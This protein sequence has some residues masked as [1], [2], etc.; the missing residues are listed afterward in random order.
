M[1]TVQLRVEHRH[2][3]RFLKQRHLRPGNKYFTIGSS[4][5]A[6]FRL[7]G[8]DVSGIHAI[9]EFREDSWWVSD[10]GT[11][12]GN[13]AGDK[14]AGDL[15]EHKISGPMKFEI[16]AHTLDVK[17]CEVRRVLFQKEARDIESSN[18]ENLV[19]QVVIRQKSHVVETQFLPIEQNFEFCY[20]IKSEVLPPPKTK[21]WV[22][23]T[24]GNLTV[25]QRLVSLS[26][27]KTQ[28][29][30]WNDILPHDM[31]KSLAQ[32]A[33]VML[34]LLFVFTVPYIG[35]KPEET[36]IPKVLN[37]YTQMVYD[38]KVVKRKVDKSEKITASLMNRGKPKGPNP[39][40]NA[41]VEAVSPKKN[42][43][44]KNVSFDAGPA[45]SSGQKAIK[46][47]RAANLA[48]LIGRLSKRAVSG[49]LV[50]VNNK[51]NSNVS[52]G[53]PQGATASLASISKSAL[54]N[55]AVGA[56]NGGGTHKIGGIG[57]VGA[58]GAGS[59]KQYGALTTGSVGT[60]NVGTIEEEADVDGGLD[61]DVIAQYIS[62]QIGHIR[63]CYERQLS[64]K[65]DLYGKI[66]VQF[67]IGATGSVVQSKIGSSTLQD[68]IVEGCILK[69]VASWV[70]PT[71]K[72]GA[73]VLVSYPF[74]FKSTN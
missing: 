21:Q 15:V 56:G 2:E 44:N 20:G 32:A 38:A 49:N 69:R 72:G 24:F 68:A 37:P 70:F 53:I 9:I 23:H 52:G 46:Q 41:T 29:V 10:V 64:A 36:E 22:W 5:D 50:K 57:T 3:N 48:G 74:L 63:Y 61:R 40:P 43:L 6:D 42:L 33:L 65:P 16:G 25:Q 47:I 59:Y 71:P 27:T 14:K 28:H 12:K 4:R 18:S 60:G 35:G 8:D 31:R 58:G 67:T 26:R 55:I 51:D 66:K 39:D 45:A 73:T 30:A 11:L 54:G 19:Q 1:K 62:T 17:P 7:L 34:G 13:I